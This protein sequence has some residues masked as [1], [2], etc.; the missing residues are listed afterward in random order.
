MKRLYYIFLVMVLA[1]LPLGGCSTQNQATEVVS[2]SQEFPMETSNSELSESEVEGITSTVLDNQII[3]TE[4]EEEV[5]S[6]SSAIAI[7]NDAI[8]NINAATNEV[9]DALQYWNDNDFN[10]AEDI[11]SYELM[12]TDIMLEL[13]QLANEF[14]ESQ[15]SEDYQ[16]AWATIHDN[17]LDGAMALVECSSLDADND[18]TI[19][20]SEAKSQLELGSSEY[21]IYMDSA[22]TNIAALTLAITEDSQQTSVSKSI[23]TSQPTSVPFT[24]KYGTRTTICAHAG[25]TNYIASSGDTNCCTVHSNKCAECGCYIDEDALFCIDCIVEALGQ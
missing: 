3:T 5:I 1:I 6:N 14:S 8:D 21:V 20:G 2:I 24:N 7:L 10:T 11:L 22:L 17:I 12:W 15:P 13:T 4:S 23:S 19:T 18:G 9:I 25:C 16:S